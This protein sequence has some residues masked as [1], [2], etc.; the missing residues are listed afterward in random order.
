MH[1]LI[2]ILR[3][4]E[5]DLIRETEPE[6]MREL[7]EDA[8]ISLHS[9]VRRARKKYQTNY[10]RQASAGVAE[11][12]GRGKSRPK[13]TKAAQKA[14]VF[15]DALARVSGLLETLARQTADDLRVQR[16]AAARANRSTGPDSQTTSTAARDTGTAREHQQTSGGT[17]RDAS[18]QAAG[19][20]RQAKRDS[21]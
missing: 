5:R 19:A 11:H 14:E 8:L 20:R 10:R 12:G 3:D 6:R 15:E 16:L 17:K 13:N 1:E 2:G 18:S 7:D 4:D 9:R 21:R